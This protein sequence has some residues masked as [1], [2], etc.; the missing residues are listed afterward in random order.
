MQQKICLRG[1]QLR[2]ASPLLFEHQLG[3]PTVSNIIVADDNFA[4]ANV[5]RFHLVRAGHD[6][7][8]VKN[9]REVLKQ[10]RA[11]GQFDL[12]VTDQQMPHRTGLEVCEEIRDNMPECA[13]IPII[14]LTAKQ[15]EM[16]VDSL[17]Q[18]Y[19]ISKV[20]P[21]P[22][23]PAELVEVISELLPAGVE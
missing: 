22:F 15:L 16:D 7:T 10:L 4:L 14:L 9:G 2:V 17:Q 18:Q 3:F 12:L 13:G 11:G 8:V 6:V 20:F 23:S 5:V 21:K 1:L 19:G